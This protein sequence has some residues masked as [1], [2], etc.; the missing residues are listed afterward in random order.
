[1]RM[2]KIP[3][4]LIRSLFSSEFKKNIL[5]IIYNVS[6]LKKKKVDDKLFLVCYELLMMTRK[7]LKLFIIAFLFSYAMPFNAANSADCPY[8]EKLS[9]YVKEQREIQTE[10]RNNLRDLLQGREMAALSVNELFVVNMNNENVVA[11]RVYDLEANLS[12]VNNKLSCAIE[13]EATKWQ[14]K[15]LAS[16]NIIVNKQ[17]LKFLSLPKYKRSTLIR[18]QRSFGTKNPGQLDT[19]KDKQRAVRR[20]NE[21]KREFFLA[22]KTFERRVEKGLKKIASERQ[23]LERVKA[24]LARYQ[25]D[26]IAEIRAE[27]KRYKKISSVLEKNTKKITDKTSTK[28]LRKKYKSVLKVWRELVDDAY[29][30]VF[31]NNNDEQTQTIDANDSSAVDN[32][33]TNNDKNEFSSVVPSL[34]PYP[35]RLLYRYR[36]SAATRDYK[37]SLEDAKEYRA[38]IFSR[39]EDKQKEIVNVHYTTLQEA[40]DL[41]SSVIA[42]LRKK[43]A[44]PVKINKN[45]FKDLYREVKVV[46]YKIV[47]LARA[48]IKYLAENARFTKDGILSI[49][50]HFGILMLI[51]LV[52]TVIRRI[53][54]RPTRHIYNLRN[55]LVANSHQSSFA[56]IGA[57]WIQRITPFLSWFTVL[58]LVFIVGK[59]IENTFMEDLTYLL[60]FVRYYVYY[61]ILKKVFASSLVRMTVQSNIKATR[62]T[63]FLITTTSEFIGLFVLIPSCLL[64]AIYSANSFGFSY[65]LVLYTTYLVGLI[66]AF[67][68]AYLWR[69]DLA[70]MLISFMPSLFKDTKYGSK[71]IEFL[72]DKKISIFTA[73]FGF[74]TLVFYYAIYFVFEQLVEFELVRVIAEKILKRKLKGDDMF[75]EKNMK[76]S[77]TYIKG[78][79][80]LLPAKKELF[81]SPKGL[82]LDSTIKDITDWKE[83]LSEENSMAI[84][85]DKGAGKSCLLAMIENNLNNTNVIKT[86]LTG[87]YLTEKDVMKHFG[88]VFGIDLENKGVSALASFDKTAKKTVIFIDNAENLFLSKLGG[89]DGFKAF[90]SLMNSE[91]DNI[92]WCVAFNRYSWDYL[93]AVFKKNEYFRIVKELPAWSEPDIKELILSRH[94]ETNFKLV[95]DDIISAAQEQGDAGDYVESK[96]FR[97]L[98]IQSHGNPQIAIYLWISSLRQVAKNSLKVG[99]LEKPKYTLLSKLKDEMFFIFAELVRHENLTAKELVDVTNTSDGLVR[100]ALKMGVDAG[101]INKV[102]SRYNIRT[103]AQKIIV[104]FLKKKNFIQD[105]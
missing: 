11:R 98:W 56:R 57:V 63:K 91:V 85:G 16:L 104:N 41:R 1:M 35:S 42:A 84:Y 36:S 64:Y 101:I 31:Y 13:N 17:R 55:T 52:P 32:V 71:Y 90:L 68:I 7:I 23:T 81:L 22:Q 103:H 105:E 33:G 67:Y 60:P 92:F 4:A 44:S 51:L 78:V 3:D 46:P 27:D 9:K 89:F 99:L 18:Q 77:A 43:E 100:Y 93:N 102:K 69:A 2:E 20:E 66:L 97:M 87:K 45:Y 72:A 15:K 80:S 34:P 73:F 76:L 12:Y 49:A 96:F 40:S 65:E 83:E 70:K 26:W 47:V 19:K 25:I 39:I 29:S 21:A 54:V 82:S 88:E 94:D 6:F 50:Q 14:A 75:N 58:L 61:R 8:V 62:K 53:L 37:A 48:E 5:L 59:Y 10:T 86:S 95:Y 28:T 30:V 38:E 74:V 24:E 79:E